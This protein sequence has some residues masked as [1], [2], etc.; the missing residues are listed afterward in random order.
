MPDI[1]WTPQPKQV[2]F[3]ARA[4]DEGLYGGAAGGGKSEALIV[5]ALRQ[6]NIPH[7]KGL[8]LRKTYPQL[9]E[10]IDKSLGYYPRAFPGA[11]YNDS[12]HIWT[13]PSGAK[14]VFGSMQHAADKTQYQGHAYDYIAFDE[15]THFTW[16]EYSYLFSRNRANGPGTRVYMR[17]T[18]NPGGVGHGW[19]KERFITA[20]TPGTT[21]W[22]QVK[23]KYPDGH[24]EKRLKSRIFVPSTVF[25]NQIQ[26]KNDPGYLTKLASMPEA[27]RKALLYG[28]WDTFAGQVFC[29][30]K[31][32]PDRYADR[33]NTH[34]INPFLI[35]QNWKVYRA[36]DWGYSRPYACHWYAVDHDKRMYCI[37]ELYGCTGQPN[38]GIR[39][40]PSHVAQE[41]KRIEAEDPNLKGRSIY[42]VADPAIF[43]STGAH[44]GESI[45]SLMEACGVYWEPGDNNR[46]NGLMQIHHRLAFDDDGMPMLYVFSTCKHFIRTLPAL[47]YDETDVEDVDTDG[48]DHIYDE[49]RYICMRN[50]IS[51]SPKKATPLIVYDPL[52]LHT[53]DTKYDDYAWFRR[54]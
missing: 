48:E 19:V 23:I 14:I 8:I 3:M 24:T 34:V 29:E 27:E 10:L 20:Q 17:A 9:R 53:E 4:E 7:Y 50:P 39:W 28:D 46:I 44:S 25:D 45:A 26:L 49:L 12:K 16:D 33:I 37:R 30:W 47:V 42:G 22:E 40:E 15:L 11:R 41:I 13:F 36:F 2:V 51:P 54:N 32:D 31:N 5:E 1:V 21:I 18:A 6:V 38:V 52:D 43:N 35:P